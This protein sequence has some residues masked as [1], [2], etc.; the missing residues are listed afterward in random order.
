M[1]IQLSGG[2]QCLRLRWSFYNSG[3]W[4]SGGSERVALR[5]WCEFNISASAREGMWWDKIFLKDDLETVISSWLSGKKMWH[6]AVAWWY[7]TKEMR[8]WGREK[9]EMTLVGLTWILLGRKI[10]KICAINL[11]GINRRGRFKEA[12]G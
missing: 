12:M 1:E 4:E 6:G 2:G 9:E 11:V 3:E 5:R 10:K 7:Q 8:H